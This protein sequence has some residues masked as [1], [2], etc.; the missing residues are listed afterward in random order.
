MTARRIIVPGAMPSRDQ[1]GRALP[2][3]L[4]F[5]APETALDTPAVVYLD[6]ALATPAPWPLISDAAGRFPSIW[7]EAGAAFDVA[8]SDQ[9]FDRRIGAFTGVTPVV[10]AASKDDIDNS[11]A[12]AA[13][14]AT[15]AAGSATAASGSATA[16]AGSAITAGNQA[17]AAAGSASAATTRASE[18]AA[19]AAAAAAQ[20]NLIAPDGAKV[21]LKL[22][23][24]T[25]YGEVSSAGQPRFQSV[26]F[27]YASAELDF[28]P[29][30]EGPSG[31]ILGWFYKSD[32]KWDTNPS[33]S[34]ITKITATVL[35]IAQDTQAKT[36]KFI[37]TSEMGA[38]R[39]PVYDDSGNFA[40]WI[41]RRGYYNF[42]GLKVANFDAA[43]VS[44]IK[45]QIGVP[46]IPLGRGEPS[47]VP[48]LLGVS[49]IMVD[50]VC[51]T[52]VRFL[53]MNGGSLHAYQTRRDVASPGAMIEEATGPIQLMISMGDSKEAGGSG[54]GWVPPDPV[55]NL[56]APY[57]HQALMLSYPGIRA[58][59]GEFVFDPNAAN[60]LVP[61][62]EV[63]MPG[64]TQGTG[65]M[66]W[67][68]QQEIAAGERRVTRAYLSAGK[69]GSALAGLVSGT[70]PYINMML[71]LEKFV[72][73]AAKYGRTVECDVFLKE[74]TN[75]QK[76]RDAAYVFG[77]MT[78][79]RNSMMTDI[80]AR[81]GQSRDPRFF[82]S[83]TESTSD[84]R[85]GN[86]NPNNIN[87]I[88]LGQLQLAENYSNVYLTTC[89]YYFVGD[90]AFVDGIH[91]RN[92]GYV[93]DGECLAEAERV[94]AA[95]GSWK[96]FRVKAVTRSVATIDVEFYSDNLTGPL[97]IDTTTRAAATFGDT[98]NGFTV[99]T[100]GGAPLGINGIA[101]ISGQFKI[102]I[103]L[104]ADPGAQ[105]DVDY[106]WTV[107][108]GATQMA[109]T[110][111]NVRDSA[112]IASNVGSVG[113]R[114][115]WALPF[116][117]RTAS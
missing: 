80:V 86:P 116:L 89:P 98:V 45:S 18:A 11:A 108:P 71:A 61:A 9:L 2:A 41:D 21:A 59:P 79:Q 73:L 60:D 107:G 117:K 19:S 115:H 28:V 20:G 13:S 58:T 69:S 85:V 78:A 24:G 31:E 100:T 84:N 50:R 47:D 22:P 52:A 54:G 74:G 111:G 110:W 93:L 96:G 77:M 3:R 29:Y 67:L 99:R 25:Q 64:E 102:R 43:T 101:V 76:Q 90:C 104:S 37:A 26:A 63:S 53:A 6:E 51:S 48:V 5:Y 36:T 46:E 39:E 34:V 106:A 44:L 72:A 112:A 87:D 68:I 88:A 16:A 27:D 33:D 17:T 114:A 62:H 55:Q 103:T 38:I 1:N 109:G 35:P 70:Q 65:S 40:S 42:Y 95:N 82:V 30:P 23:S 113:T 7:A 66:R 105:V 83:V 56:S 94:V 4:R 81:T 75:D 8:W 32:G 15:A 10:P 12:A 57:P 49:P 92:P 91:N 97:V 14:S